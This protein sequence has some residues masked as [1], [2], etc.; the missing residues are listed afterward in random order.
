MIETA[1][2]VYEVPPNRNF[3]SSF[4]EVAS[5]GVKRDNIHHEMTVKSNFSAIKY[6]PIM[7]IPSYFNY[8]NISD[9][10]MLQINEQD[11]S[12]YSIMV[13]TGFLHQCDEVH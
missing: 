9:C 10:A 12:W 7:F 5:D 8:L 4:D 2:R 13:F 6:F 3:H 11:C 1:L